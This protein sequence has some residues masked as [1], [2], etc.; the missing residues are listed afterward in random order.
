MLT[1]VD[2]FLC[3]NFRHYRVCTGCLD[4]PRAFLGV[5]GCSMDSRDDVVVRDESR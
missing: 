3:V 5:D 1:A 2:S 4:F